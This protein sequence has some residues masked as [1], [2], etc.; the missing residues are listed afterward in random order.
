[1]KISNWRKRQL[2]LLRAEGDVNNQELDRNQKVFF[3]A[4]RSPGRGGKIKDTWPP[5]LALFS[6]GCES[7]SKRDTKRRTFE[8]VI[9]S[10]VVRKGVGELDVFFSNK[11]F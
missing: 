2:D 9:T 7:Q 6:K 5:R 1:M 3:F 11:D 10:T 8:D 4:I